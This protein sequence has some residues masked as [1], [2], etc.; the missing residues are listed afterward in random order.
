MEEYGDCEQQLLYKTLEE[1]KTRKETGL[2]TSLKFP[3]LSDK[4]EDWLRECALVCQPAQAKAEFCFPNYFQSKDCNRWLKQDSTCV[5]TPILIH[6]SKEN[7]VEDWLRQI[8]QKEDANNVNLHENGESSKDDQ[9]SQVSESIEMISHPET[10][11][12]TGQRTSSFSS[13]TDSSG[14]CCLT[15]RTLTTSNANPKKETW[16]SCC[17]GEVA[18]VDIE[19]LHTISCTAGDVSHSDEGNKWLFKQVG[20][21]KTLEPSFEEI[22]ASIC[23]SN[24]LCTDLSECICKEECANRAIERQAEFAKKTDK[25]SPFRTVPEEPTWLRCAGAGTACKKLIESLTST[26]SE[27][28]DISEKVPKDEA[29]IKTNDDSKT[30]QNNKCCWLI[31]NNL[32]LSKMDSGNCVIRTDFRSYFLPGSLDTW[33]V[34]LKA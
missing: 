30:V 24:E 29:W 10:D 13:S 8:G 17:Q 20:C 3:K 9:Q 23:C 33:L 22:W 15:K 18:N 34:T 28:I 19:N 11:C 5:K 21:K 2:Q 26:H 6:Y 32:E 27:K 14:Y 7:K 31:P 25:N 1:I 4:T 16:L 12:S